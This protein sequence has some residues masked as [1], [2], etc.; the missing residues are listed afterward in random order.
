MKI[1][2]PA[3]TVPNLIEKRRVTPAMPNYS[4]NTV[5]SSS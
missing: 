4:M 3:S 5:R 2:V 1:A